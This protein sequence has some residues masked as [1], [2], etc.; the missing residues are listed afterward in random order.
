[1]K[2]QLTI[3]GISI[4]LVAGITLTAFQQQDKDKGNKQEQKQDKGKGQDKTDKSGKANANKNDNAG[5]GQGNQPGNQ[6]KDK[7]DKPGL[8]NDKDKSDNANKGNDNDILSPGKSDRPNVKMGKDKKG[9]DIFVWDRE[10][11]RD[12]DK[13]RKAEKV[14]ICHKFNNGDEPPVTINVS[15]NA[16][17]AHL[18]HGDVLGD[19]PAFTD[20]RYSDIFIDRR[21]DYYNILQR[22]YEQQLYSRSVLDYALQRLGVYRTDLVTLQNN[23]A[24]ADVIQ[25]RQVAIVDLER[26]VSLLETLLG[27]AAGLA[28]NKLVN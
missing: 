6:G 5:Q 4:L 26:N 1:M 2:K 27:V 13:V 18:N 24:P 10:T 11:F 20:N 25:S 8:G 21:N 22:N 12:R 28:V 9:K 3:F 23:N 19:C 16:Q 14:T 7:D 17:E 15:V